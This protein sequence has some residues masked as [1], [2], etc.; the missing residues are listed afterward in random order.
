MQGN[1]RGGHMALATRNQAP[2]AKNGTPC[3][4][5]VVYEAVAAD[6]AE[7]RELNAILYEEGNTQAQV[8]KY[9]TDDGYTIGFQTV[10]KHR[11]KNCRCFLQ[12][13]FNFCGE[14]KRDLP[15][16]VCA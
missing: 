16:C 2:P 9:L 15:S 12:A 5:A 7:L 3:S 14:C 1:T 11:G 10:N 8:F 13:P 4:I 6:P